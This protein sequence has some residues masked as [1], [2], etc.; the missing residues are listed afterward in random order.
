MRMAMASIMK[1]FL[2]KKKRKERGMML[3]KGKKSGRRRR[4]EAGLS[5][6]QRKLWDQAEEVEGLECSCWDVL[7]RCVRSYMHVRWQY[8]THSRSAEHQ[9]FC[10]VSR[11]CIRKTPR[12]RGNLL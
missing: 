9:A 2:M 3:S 8:G 7:G 1:V 11:Q 10:S 12:V 4:R 6:R 5:Q